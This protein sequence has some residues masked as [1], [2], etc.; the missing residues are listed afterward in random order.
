MRPAFL[1]IVKTI[2]GERGRRVKKDKFYFFQS[3][4]TFVDTIID[5][6]HGRLGR[7]PPIGVL[8]FSQSR[9]HVNGSR[10]EFNFLTSF[11]FPY[12]R[13]GDSFGTSSNPFSV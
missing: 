5:E 6:F 12:W 9:G 11:F 2:L 10:E 1:D 4:N 7:L 8:R 13:K 3:D